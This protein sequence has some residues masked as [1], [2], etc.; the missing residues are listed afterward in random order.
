V[1]ETE[2]G[3][4]TNSYELLAKLAMGGMAE[5][6]LARASAAGV[7]RY[8]VLKRV[9]RQ[10]AQDVRFMQMF[11]DEARLAAQLQHANIAQVH[12]IG[13]LGDSFFFTM[14]YVH[15]ETLVEIFARANA[16]QRAIPIG[17]VLTI[18]AGAAAGLHYAH[19]R[20]GVDG[21]PLG[22]VHRDVSPSNLM[23]TYEGTVK[24]VDFG[25][26]KAGHRTRETSTGTIKGKLSY[27]SP[28]QCRGKDM[29]RR[30]DLFSLGIVMW[31]MLT[32]ERLFKVTGTEYEQMQ[33]IVRDPTP[34]PSSRRADVPP[35][36]DAVV[37]KLLEKD[38]DQR[39][40]SADELLEAIEA[41]A[42]RTGSVLSTA[43]LGRFV[44]EL[45]GR[46]P[47]PWIEIRSTV[48]P[49]IV[50]VTTEPVPEELA[51]P[52]ADGTSTQLA[53]LP[54]LSVGPVRVAVNGSGAT[55][56]SRGVSDKVAVTKTFSYST[57][58]EPPVAPRRRSRAGWTLV[59]LAA[60][61]AGIAAVVWQLRSDSQPESRPPS[62]STTPPADAARPA[63]D[64]AATEV[65]TEPVDAGAATT[66]G[67]ELPVDAGVPANVRTVRTR[68]RHPRPD[69]GVVTPPPPRPDAGVTVPVVVKPD[70]GVARP[71]KDCKA[72]PLAC[73]F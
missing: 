13:Q 65:A 50:T 46:R 56:A 21:V 49:D 38:P 51:V 62:A 5:I 39:F 1:S 24:L 18:V 73:Q 70:A 57:L 26:A 40:Q 11:L 30:S 66:P 28:E 36:L 12:D 55:P 45:C 6:F 37:A 7:D 25:V 16:Q 17:C 64:D 47:E 23:I 60:L 27:M 68:P 53:K 72:D 34:A 22:I 67:L 4:T 32:G 35:E 48:A 33:R 52:I 8:V 14:E 3:S 20:I 15:G 63:T 10:R 31:E 61:A 9:L 2:V 44:R 42:V 71:K 41:I 69:A 54:D 29:D 59:A 58:H 19:E 43:G